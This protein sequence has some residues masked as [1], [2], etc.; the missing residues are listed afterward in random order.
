MKIYFGEAASH[1]F[2]S[3]TDTVVSINRQLGSAASWEPMPTIL[4][5]IHDLLSK[6]LQM[7]DAFVKSF[8]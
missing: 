2:D 3:I 1:A 5:P 4:A 8:T 7:N 6:F